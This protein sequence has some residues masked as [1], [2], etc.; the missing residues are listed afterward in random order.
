MQI[1][2]GPGPDLE[3]M[4]DARSKEILY[5]NGKRSGFLTAYH[6]RTNTSKDLVSENATQPLL[7][8]DGK[9][10]QLPQNLQRE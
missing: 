5:V 4:Y 6:P 1:T 9:H 2:F 3:P 8:R 10:V 7:S